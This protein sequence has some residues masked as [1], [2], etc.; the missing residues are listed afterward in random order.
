MYMDNDSDSNGSM[1]TVGLVFLMGAVIGA[2]VGLLLAPKS[3]AETRAILAAKAREAKE[4]AAEAAEM[5]REK[6]SIMRNRADSHA[7]ASEA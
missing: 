6:A 7:R 4:K 2:G 1:L 3:G 5:V